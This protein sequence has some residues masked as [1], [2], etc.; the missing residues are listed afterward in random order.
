MG[1][2]T[3]TGKY[4]RQSISRITAR[5]AAKKHYQIE[6]NV[7][8]SLPHGGSL[9]VPLLLTNQSDPDM[10]VIVDTMVMTT[11][12]TTEYK[13]TNR[14]MQL[15]RVMEVDPRCKAAILVRG[16]RKWTRSNVDFLTKDFAVYVPRAAGRVHTVDANQFPRFLRSIL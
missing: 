15:V 11:A 10:R 13:A 1:G 7:T 3:V 5:V 9:K 2:R 16:G 6:L 8:F 14:M 4:F 12:G